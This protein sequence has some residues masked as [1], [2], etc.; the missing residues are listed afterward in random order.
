[1][2][3]VAPFAVAALVL[4]PRAAASPTNALPAWPGYGAASALPGRALRTE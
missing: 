2:L 3:Y 1:M 4:I